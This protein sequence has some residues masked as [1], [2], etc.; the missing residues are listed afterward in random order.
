M[1]TGDPSPITED[2]FVMNDA[3]LLVPLAN[4]DP[5]A[6]TAAP[7]K[8][9]ANWTL[10][11]ANELRDLWGG[12]RF[13]DNALDLLNDAL[14]DPNYDPEEPY[15]GLPRWSDGRIATK[16][17]V[18]AHNP[19]AKMAQEMCAEIDAE[20]LKELAQH[21]PLKGVKFSGL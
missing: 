4:F 10:E 7:R 2:G 5:N 3:G 18:D 15:V 19:V 14:D 12:P 16:E 20:I 9:K 21:R 1:S 17:E 8:L 6:I 11:A 13:P